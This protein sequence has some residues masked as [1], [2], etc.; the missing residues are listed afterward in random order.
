MTN[1]KKIETTHQLKNGTSEYAFA[2]AAF[3]DRHPVALN[4]LEV[5]GMLLCQL[6]IEQIL[7]IDFYGGSKEV[8]VK[9]YY[10]VKGDD[11]DNAESELENSSAETVN[12][13]PEVKVQSGSKFNDQVHIQ[14]R[15]RNKDVIDI[16]V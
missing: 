10:K 4:W 5:H 14:I 6:K 3:V 7:V 12:E 11:L 1:L 2:R 9:D 13:L 8:S 15:K 16:F